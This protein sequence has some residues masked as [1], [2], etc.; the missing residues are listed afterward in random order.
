MFDCVITVKG[1]GHGKNGHFKTD[2]TGPVSQFM[3]D[4]IILYPIV[5]NHVAN[6]PQCDPTEAVRRYLERRMNPKFGG[7]V[8]ESLAKLAMSY[9]RKCA[10]TRP[11]P[12]ELVNEFICR[13]RSR[14]LILDNEKRLSIRE[15][16][17]AA[18]FYIEDLRTT[19]TMSVQELVN[20]LPKTS[21]FGLVCQL[22]THKTV[23]ETEQELED[24]IQVAEVTL[25]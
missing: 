15:L 4:N 17:Q 9:E 10:K 13:S 24:L 18:G 3:V 11:I 22:L 25:S 6:C 12:K 19:R 20:K 23:P 14:D 8:T 7:R 21:K 2:K 5:K 1:D 16:V